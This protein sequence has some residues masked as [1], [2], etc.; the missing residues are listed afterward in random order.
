MAL[1]SRIEV[2]T[3]SV[4]KIADLTA[5]SRTVQSAIAKQPYDG[6]IIV[7]TELGI[8]GDEHADPK[9]HGG[10][11][12]AIYVYPF[13]HYAAWEQDFRLIDRDELFGTGELKVPSFGENLT[14]AG[15]VDETMVRIGDRLGWGDEVILQVT[16]PRQPCFKLNAQLGEPSALDRMKSNGRCGWYCAVERSGEVPIGAPLFFLGHDPGSPNLQPTVREAFFAKV[17]RQSSS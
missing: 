8:V 5:G 13:R 2:S 3:V 10:Q 17:R 9:N 14:I 16:K 15:D 1:P 7:V 6:E 12:K 11:E 4:G